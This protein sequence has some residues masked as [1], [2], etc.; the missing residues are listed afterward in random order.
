MLTALRFGEKRGGE[1]RDWD[2]GEN[3]ALTA[4]AEERHSIKGL[5]RRHWLLKA[6]WEQSETFYLPV[7]Q[8]SSTKAL[9]H[10][11]TF[12]HDDAEIKIKIFNHKV[13]TESLQWRK[14]NLM[15]AFS[16][17]AKCSTVPTDGSLLHWDTSHWD[18][19]VLWELILS[20]DRHCS[21]W[22]AELEAKSLW[23]KFC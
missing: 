9:D 10:Q 7:P 22:G 17:P 14:I 16:F 11:T 20:T 12:L 5:W 15:S 2:V 13:T 23:W 21:S 8:T 6:S 18:T 3:E 19:L 1:P 4:E